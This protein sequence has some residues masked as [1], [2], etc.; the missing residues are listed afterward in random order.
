MILLLL[1]CAEDPTLVAAVAPTLA[2]ADRNQDGRVDADEY[3]SIA[4]AAPAFAEADRGGDG[5]FD[6]ADAAALVRATDPTTF[7][8]DTLAHATPPA[9]VGGGAPAPGPAPLG[10]DPHVAD[11]RQLLRFLREEVVARNPAVPVP[12]EAR[13][14]AAARAGTLSGPDVV[15][16]LGELHVAWAAAGLSFPEALSPRASAT[17]PQP[18]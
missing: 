10:V 1:A 4:Y 11:V 17:P 7:D 3:R 2:R 16:I 8:P 5:A 14:T 13:I 6:A 18:G 12:T 9:P 15:Q